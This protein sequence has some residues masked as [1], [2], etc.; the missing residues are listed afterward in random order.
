MEGDVVVVMARCLEAKGVLVNEL[1]PRGAWSFSFL[2]FPFFYFS[3]STT[4][5]PKDQSEI[6]EVILA[7]LRYLEWNDERW[8]SKQHDDPKTKREEKERDGANTV[9]EVVVGRSEG[10]KGERGGEGTGTANQE[11]GAPDQQVPGMERPVRS[12]R[13]S[14]AHST[15]T[16][17][18]ATTTTTI[19]GP[20]LT[21]P[22][23]VPSFL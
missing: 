10:K 22:Y 14:S 1:E 6:G 3:Q 13:V 19:A 7:I 4:K 2:F 18:I 23:V 20:D 15:T 17:I 11:W 9:G 5:V 21:D 16:T 8:Y 12:L